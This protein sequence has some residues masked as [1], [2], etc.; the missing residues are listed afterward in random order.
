MNRDLVTPCMGVWIETYCKNVNRLEED[1]TPC[2]GVWIETDVVD[3]KL[4]CS[5]SHPVWVCGLKPPWKPAFKS[6]TTSHPVW[7][8]GLKH[9]HR[10]YLKYQLPVTPCMGVWI[11]TIT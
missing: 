4:P 2:M 6:S 7:V 9:N 5:L 3:D 1:V 11:E 10:I 8:C